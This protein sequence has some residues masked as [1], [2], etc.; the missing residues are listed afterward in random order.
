[1]QLRHIALHCESAASRL[2]GKNLSREKTERVVGPV[3]KTVV[4]TAQYN[5][6]KMLRKINICSSYRIKDECVGG[7]T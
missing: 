3:I 2:F 6:I 4:G 5:L 1:M 7:I